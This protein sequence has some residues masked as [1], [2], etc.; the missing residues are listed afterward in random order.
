MS[1]ILKNIVWEYWYILGMTAVSCILAF[2]L[3]KA[4]ISVIFILFITELVGIII[5]WTKALSKKLLY[6][7]NVLNCL[8]AVSLADLLVGTLIREVETFVVVII[9]IAVIDVFSFTRAG[10]KTPNAILISKSNTVA[11][12]SI[13]LPVPGKPGLQPIIGVG[14]LYFYAVITIFSLQHFGTDVF[15]KVFL[16]ILSGQLINI[17]LIANLKNKVWYKGFPATL[18]PGI[19]CIF[20]CFLIWY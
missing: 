11:R 14:D 3:E 18:F 19:L 1:K 15:G 6:V 12:L 13:C 20:A 8:A 7:L 10:R 2:F 16:L 9:V 4:A 5:L 17:L